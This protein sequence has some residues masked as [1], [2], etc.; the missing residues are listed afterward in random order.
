MANVSTV[1]G[2][3]YGFRIMLYAIAVFVIAVVFFVGSAFFL[4][5]NEGVF[6]AIGA[7]LGFLGALIAYAG[8]LG[9]LYKVI[10]DGVERGVSAADGTLRRTQ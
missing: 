9:L 10:A 1:E 6:R 5:M 3:G 4:D 7:L 8:A 2:I